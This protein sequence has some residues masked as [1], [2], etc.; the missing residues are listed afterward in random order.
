[1]SLTVF[2]MAL[3]SA[4]LHAVWNTLARSRPDPGFGFAAM[5]VSAGVIGLPL[6]AYAG[7]PDP[8]SF[9]WLGCSSIWRPCV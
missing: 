9:V 1:M 7:L 8:D 4:V 5:V 3:G 2:L 6:L